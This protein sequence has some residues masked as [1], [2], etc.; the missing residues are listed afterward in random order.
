MVPSK[1]RSGGRPVSTSKEL[2]LSEARRRLS[3]APDSVPFIMKVW[4]NDLVEWLATAHPAA[5][6][7]SPKT[8]G[9]Y[10]ADLHRI[11][12]HR[13]YQTR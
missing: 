5:P 12:K 8:V 9:M 10:L 1:R 3:E 11:A 6:R 4:A 13:K 7:M 2:I